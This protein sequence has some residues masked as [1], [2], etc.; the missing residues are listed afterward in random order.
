[1]KQ[2]YI[3]SLRRQLGKIA[4]F[5]DYFSRMRRG[6]IYSYAT[7]KGFNKVALGHHLDDAVESFFMNMLYNGTLR[8]MP[9]IYRAERGFL[10]IRPLIE[11]RESQ[12]KAFVKDNGFETIGDEACPAMRVNIKNPYARDKMKEWLKSIEYEH[13]NL[14]K[15]LKASFKHIHDD[16]F[17]DPKRW[18]V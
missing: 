13:K 15:M 16:T 7:E 10:V 12:L 11:I 5:V 3:K 2:K 4:L 14:F 9:P 18:R 6:A 17:F 8:S 1:M